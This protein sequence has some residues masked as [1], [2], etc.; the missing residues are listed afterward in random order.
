MLQAPVCEY[1]R[2]DTGSNIALVGMIHVGSQEYFDRIGAYVGHRE[3]AGAA[4]HYELTK[5]FTPEER[6]QHPEYSGLDLELKQA[7][8]GNIALFSRPFNLVYQTK[9]L[10]YSPEWQ[11][12]DMSALEIIDSLGIDEVRKTIE[13]A[14]RIQQAEIFNDTDMLRLAVHGAFRLVP[15]VSAVRR[16]RGKDKTQEVIV[17]RRNA[18]ALAAVRNTLGADPAAD[19]TLIW[20]AGHLPG[21]GKGLQQMGYELR[22]KAWVNA[23]SLRPPK[24]AAAS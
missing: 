13:N 19:L 5:P 1:E 24:T 21:L 16:L 9:A 15:L 8:L 6:E 4:V 11:N 12:H 23:F 22:R 17:D 2:D 20:G 7:M 18:V 10:R 3:A 14:K